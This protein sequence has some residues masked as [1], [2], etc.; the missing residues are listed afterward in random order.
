MAVATTFNQK[1]EILATKTADSGQPSLQ[2][3]FEFKM[4]LVI[5]DLVENSGTRFL[6]ADGTIDQS[7][8]L[9]TVNAAQIIFIMADGELII[10]IVNSAG[11]SQALTLVPDRPSIFHLKDITDILVTNNT[12]DQIKGKFFSVGD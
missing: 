7:I 8:G 11:T 1:L 6:I 4:N 2:K 5:D 3:D 10:K 12:G 9:T